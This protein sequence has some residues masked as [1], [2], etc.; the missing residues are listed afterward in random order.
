[1]SNVDDFDIVDL[2]NEI[3]KID[4]N[5]LSLFE[6]R[7]EVVLKI[8]QYKKKN[9]IDILNAAR[10][11]AVIKE[12][13]D[14]VKNKDLLL[15][16]EEF[17]KSVMEISRGYQ[18]KNLNTDGVL[19][20]DEKLTVGFYGVKGSFSE[21]A[22]KGYFG[23]KVYTKAIS[24]FEDIFLDLRYGKINYGVIPIENSS[25]GAISEVY[26]LL[27]KY[28]FYIIGEKYLKISQNLMG[29]K[30][31]YSHPQGLEQSMEYLKGY[32]HWKLIPFNSTAKSAELVKERRDKT[33]AAIASSKASE[34]YGLKILQKN[35]NSNATNTTRFVVIGKEMEITNKNDKISLVLS[36]THKAG[37]LYNVL[38]H[39]AE[40][41]IN[42]LKIESRPIV[43]KPWEY[44]F[45][46]DFEGNINEPKVVTSIELIKLNSRY[47]KTL[48][49]YRSS[50]SDIK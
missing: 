21:E 35:V 20:R 30:E 33:L 41:N 31:V 48:G 49:N 43:D 7:M 8:A 36:T 17:F 23:E 50:I 42:L 28:S 5:L 1:M 29:I 40:N 37:S 11:E 10:E 2:R 14:L 9:N 4:G 39:F 15:E 6:K 45:Y 3:D 38:K 22:L 44:F 34:I 25:T 16:V 24:E 47:F 46:I 27:N 32:K 12:T 26:D 18:N 13:L 19:I